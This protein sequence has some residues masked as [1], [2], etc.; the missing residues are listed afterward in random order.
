MNIALLLL[1]VTSMWQQPKTSRELPIRQGAALRLIKTDHLRLFH[2][3]RFL[4]QAQNLAMEGERFIKDLE[5]TWAVVLPHEQVTVSLLMADNTYPDPDHLPDDDY[6]DVVYRQKAKRIELHVTRKGLDRITQEQLNQTLRHHLVHVF[7]DHWE[8]DRLP[9]FFEEGLAQYYDQYTLPT[10]TYNLILAFNHLEK[11]PLPDNLDERGFFKN[12]QGPYYTAVAN[13]FVSDLWAGKSKQEVTF[14]QRHLIGQ[15]LD[16]TLLNAG[17]EPFPDLLGTFLRGRAELY[18]MA[19]LVKTSDFWAI[20]F[21][22]LFLAAAAFQIVRAAR[23]AMM[24]H[25]EL[26]VEEAVQAPVFATPAARQVGA[27]GEPQFPPVGPNRQRAAGAGQTA[28][29]ATPPS[30][31]APRPAPARNDDADFAAQTT[32]ALVFL[33]RE[34]PR[35]PVA[36]PPSA[37]EA[38]FAAQTTESLVFID[39]EAPSPTLST[40]VVPP[41]RAPITPPRRHEKTVQLESTQPSHAQKKPLAGPSRAPVPSP[42]P[43]A[44]QQQ[45]D[46]ADESFNWDLNELEDDLDS[47]FDLLGGKEN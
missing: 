14:I 23:E 21:G 43:R 12:H 9:F 40:G 36:A 22:I 28:P 34:E 27:D 18:P 4:E 39:D 8:V 5:T 46:P 15:P 37:D 38:D 20:F 45:Q 19:R 44:P 3:K 17:L 6:I 16:L 32:D 41:P 25:V 30:T 35:A 26:V 24:E 1:C 13:L 11:N 42:P 47:A 2:H 33:E 10:Y 29:P 7:L 31:P